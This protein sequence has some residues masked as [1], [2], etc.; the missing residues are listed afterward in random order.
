MRDDTLKVYDDLEYMG[1]SDL[2]YCLKYF[3]ADVRKQDGSK[4]PPKTLKGIFATIQHYMNYDC[5]KIGR[6]LKMMSSRMQGTN[7]TLK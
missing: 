7:S 5:G 4:Y 6:S 2:S 3:I 1:A